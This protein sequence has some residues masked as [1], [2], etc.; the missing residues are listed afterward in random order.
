MDGFSDFWVLVILAAAGLAAGFIDSIVGGGGLISVPLLSILIGPGA[1]AI[2]TN[3][4]AAV[5][6]SAFALFVY[7][8]GGHVAFRGNLIF[9]LLTGM[10]AGVGALFAP[11][12]P[13]SLYKWILLLI[14]PVILWVVFR[15]DIWVKREIAHDPGH[16]SP[17]SMTLLWGA[18]FTCGF[19]DG[20]AGP[21][22]GTFMFLSLFLVARTPLLA[23]MATA[24]LANLASASVSLVTFASTGHVLWGKA[25]WL[26][27]GISLGAITGALIV[28]RHPNRHAAPLAR[29]ALAVLAL[30]L[31]GRL[32]FT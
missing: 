16:D 29:V 15:K 26:A 30:I 11:W 12:I 31:L 7:M 3:K 9:A 24:K 19:Y 1:F 22:G 18:G 2:G 23:A 17:P 28:T 4:V 27:V 21:G 20:L 6:A 13:P 8:R 25:L 14:G 10:G 32:A 5:C